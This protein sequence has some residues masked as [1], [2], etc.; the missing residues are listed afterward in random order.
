MLFR[1]IIVSL[2][3]MNTLIAF[4]FTI[5]TT[6]TYNSGNKRIYRTHRIVTLPP[7]INGKLDDACWQNG[8]W[9]GNYL[10][11][12]PVEGASPTAK[13]ALNILYDNQ[14][15]YVA[16]R[17]FDDPEK[18]DRSA[19]RRD[20]FSGDIVGVCFDSYFDHRSGFEFDLTAAGTKID[21]ILMNRGIDL[22]WDP[23]WEGKVSH[24]NQG[25]SAEM[26]IPLSQLRYDEKDE[27]VWGLHAWRWINRNH[28]EDQWALVPRDTPGRL[29]DIGE[30]HGIQNL[31]RHRRIELLPYIRGKL[32]TFHAEKNHPFTDGQDLNGA[33]G[34]NGKIGLSSDLTL[35]FTLNPDFG[36][37]EA[38]PAD[39]NLSAFETFFSE[40]RPFF[41]EGKNIMDFELGGSELFYSRR[42]GAKPAYS[43]DPADDEYVDMPENT[44]ILGAVKMTGKT[45]NGLSIGIMESVTGKESAETGVR[46]HHKNVTVAPLTNFLVT[47]VQK[48]FNDSNTMLGGIITATHRN[49]QHEHLRELPDQAWTGGVDF[50]HYWKDK[51]YYIDGKAVFS[52]VSGDPLAI[53]QR[54]TSSARYFQRPD[55]DYISVDSSR[56]V[57][58]GNGGELEIGKGGNGNWRFELETEWRTPGLELNDLGFM[59]SADYIST[60]AEVAYVENKP[61]SIFRSMAVSLSHNR[62]WTFGR[63]LF[64]NRTTLQIEGQLDNKWRYYAHI[65]RTG[66]ALNPSLLRGGP[67]MREEGHWCRYVDIY[68][69]DSRNISG[70]IGIHS[71]LHDKKKLSRNFDF[72]PH[73]TLKLGAKARLRTQM[74]YSRS[75]DPFQYIEAEAPLYVTARL[76]RET[77]GLTLRIDFSIT[78]DFTIQFYGNPYFSNGQYSRYKSVERPQAV[79]YY[80]RYTLLNKEITYSADE[81]VFHVDSDFNNE[82]ELSFDDPDFN[83]AE[84]RSNVVARWEFSPGSTLFFVYTH[85]RSVYETITGSAYSHHLD[86]LLHTRPDNIFIIK[87][88]LWFSV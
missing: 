24:D 67:A 30:L 66:D 76:D 27:Q 68:S 74:N 58:S 33:L 73:L 46:A 28:E 9:S 85:G 4:S 72:Y 61:F 10:Q 69:D 6:R 83:F 81:K 45:S 88:N 50:L 39:L 54:Q 78:P 53:L 12:I 87:L 8:T 60:G 59:H 79:D 65:A 15:I 1:S 55:A 42:I 26:R 11:Q 37:V 62:Q 16:I 49:I 18:V 23:V 17:A 41:L 21:L 32:H 31:P 82:P 40:K 57:L 34:L 29:Y 86:N 22:N 84:F 56:S 44:S 64:Y 36:Q 75:R 77:I 51:T 43:P 35:D 25:W 38:D 13:T 52:H 48:N 47:R 3:L 70:G 2:L 20:G 80:D 19:S 7:Q 63:E 5:D 71:H 14:N